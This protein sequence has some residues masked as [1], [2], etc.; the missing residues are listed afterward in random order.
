MY[1]IFDL[2]IVLRHISMKI[3]ISTSNSMPRSVGKIFQEVSLSCGY[4]EPGLK[5]SDFKFPN[6]YEIFLPKTQKSVA[7]VCLSG[8]SQWISVCKKMEIVF[9]FFL[10]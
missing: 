10:I 2:Q 6:V 3:S 8:L 9:F 5:C 7:V 1:N 4:Y